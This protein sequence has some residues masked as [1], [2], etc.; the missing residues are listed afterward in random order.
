M[1]VL[2]EPTPNKRWKKGEDK[3]QDERKK[4]RSG[5]KGYIRVNNV[6][7]EAWGRYFL[8]YI[9]LSLISKIHVN[10]SSLI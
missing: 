9:R 2:N 7:V 6:L 10:F 4:L 5:G 1:E 3:T 8:Y